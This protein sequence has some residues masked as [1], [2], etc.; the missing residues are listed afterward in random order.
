MFKSKTAKVATVLALFT[1]LLLTF[2][3]PA[4]AF[5]S[6]EGETVVVGADEVVTD[7]LYVTAANFTLDGKVEGDLIVFGQSITINGTVEGD[8]IAAGQDVIINGTVMDDARFA[9]SALYVGDAASIGDDAVCAGYSLEL[10]PDSTVGG[11]LVYGGGQALLGGTID[12]NVKAGVGGLKVDGKVGGDITAEVGDPGEDY[13][14]PAPSL[15]MPQSTVSIPV[16]P[17]GLTVGNDAEIDGNL[18]YTSVKQFNL[19][20]NAVKGHVKHIQQ[21]VEDK[22]HEQLT[23]AR[24]VANWFL[25][26]FRRVVTLLLVGLLFVWLFPK[27]LA[28]ATGV[29]QSKPWHSLGWGVV[30]YA[31][32]FFALLVIVLAVGLAATIFGVIH[33]SGITVAIIFLGLL[34]LFALILGFVLVTSWLVNVIAGTWL[35]QAI[36]KVFKSDLAEHRV[37]PMVVGVLIVAILISLPLLGWLLS[38]A[39]IM[40]GLG[41]LWLM[42]RD[43]LANQPAE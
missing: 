12:G 39:T 16:V 3:S 31:A 8:L 6:R 26:L 11:D 30:A 24:M 27:F 43:S 28:G 15:F 1:I 41:V 33:L 32:F 7:D 37:W 21:V 42:G 36:F 18:E 19:P 25:S 20:G 9:G 40:F 23:P 17:I 5:E 34:V 35:G 13:A 38:L 2:V 22:V 10:R 29:L 14:G 4:G